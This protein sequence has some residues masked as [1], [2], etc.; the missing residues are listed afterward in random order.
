MDADERIDLKPT[1]DPGFID[2]FADE[3]A[4]VDAG[5]EITSKGPETD[6]SNLAFSP[7]DIASVLGLFSDL[8]M[9]GPIC[10]RADRGR[11]AHQAEEDRDHLAV[12]VLP[13]GA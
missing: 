11:T 1:S 5:F 6:P 13:F 3:V 10:S 12:S 9:T 7:G 8:F 2:A 4:R